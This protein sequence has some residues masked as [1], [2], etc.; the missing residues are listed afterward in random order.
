[1]AASR[2]RPSPRL[3]VLCLAVATLMLLLMACDSAATPDLD[4]RSGPTSTQAEQ[5]TQKPILQATAPNTNGQ[6]STIPAPPPPEATEQP[7]VA[8][9]AGPIRDSNISYAQVSAGFHH[10]CGLRADGSII[11]WGASGEAERL[12][13]TT[14]LIDAPSGSF[15]QISAGALH[16]CALRLDGTVECWG[17]TPMEDDMPPEAR[18]MMEAM[19][20]P[21]E[22]RF[23]SVSAGFL[24][25]RNVICLTSV[26]TRTSEGRECEGAP[27]GAPRL[28]H[29]FCEIILC[30]SVASP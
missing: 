8:S 12:T 5:P 19:S 23:I 29:R 25:S 30:G 18:A 24:F 9:D 17:G 3:S 27:A 15:S 14:G 16:S 11:C 28:L 2:R 20:A 4:H 26:M 6:T 10:T 7:N 13:E 1:M 21:P 22:G